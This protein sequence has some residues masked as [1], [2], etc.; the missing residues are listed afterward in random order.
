[1]AWCIIV[2]VLM[3]GFASIQSDVGT[4]P[5][6]QVEPYKWYFPYQLVIVVICFVYMGYVAGSLDTKAKF[7]EEK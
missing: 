2:G 6:P 1:M 3:Y 4:I 5:T 7:E